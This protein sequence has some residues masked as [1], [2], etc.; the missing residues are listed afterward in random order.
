MHAH[1]PTHTHAH[2]PVSPC[3]DASG[4]QIAVISLPN[5]PLTDFLLRLREREAAQLTHGASPAVTPS[6]SCGAPPSPPFRRGSESPSSLPFLQPPP[7]TSRSLPP[8]LPSPSNR[9]KTDSAMQTGQQK[10]PPK[11]LHTCTHSADSP[12]PS[13][14]PPQSTLTEQVGCRRQQK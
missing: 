1:T 7:S 4:E 5:R 6:S 2:R 8:L 13:L 3:K 10:H 14:R 11:K 12:F 9:K